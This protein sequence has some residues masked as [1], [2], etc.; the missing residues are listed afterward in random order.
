MT[1]NIRSLCTPVFNGGCGVMTVTHL[2]EFLEDGFFILLKSKGKSVQLRTILDQLHQRLAGRVI[3][4]KNQLN[5]TTSMRLCH[6]TC[7]AHT[8]YEPSLMT[9]DVHTRTAQSSDALTSMCGSVGCHATA[10]QASECPS[11][12]HRYFSVF[13]CHNLTSPRT[14]PIATNALFFPPNTGFILNPS[15]SIAKVGGCKR[16]R[17]VSFTA[18]LPGASSC[19]AALPVEGPVRLTL[20]AWSGALDTITSH[21]TTERSLISISKNLL[22]LENP[23]LNANSLGWK[24]ATCT[25]S[26]CFLSSQEK[27][28][29][30]LVQDRAKSQQVMGEGCAG[31]QR[32]AHALNPGGRQKALEG[33]ESSVFKTH[34]SA[35]FI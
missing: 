26:P 29:P 16:C 3:Q 12:P 9:G 27:N 2:F 31:V 23:T 34:T 25:K 20:L 8:C 15:G 14:D 33:C 22:S 32:K 21:T 35:S 5:S 28:Q 10:L 7:Q 30:H 17:N 1:D 24:D 11:N 6:T 19:G 4:C 18:P 13:Q